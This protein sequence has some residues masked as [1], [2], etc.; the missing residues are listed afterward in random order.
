M[1]TRLCAAGAA[2]LSAML[3]A[4]SA[5][6]QDSYISLSGGGAFLADSDNAGQF[7]STFTTGA[8]TTIPAGTAL[9]AGTPLGWTTAFDTGYAL[10][11]AYGFRFADTFRVEF[12][13]AY[14][15]NDIDTHSGVTAAGI[16]LDGEDAGV[17]ITGSPNLGVSVGAL[18]DDGQGGVDTTYLMANVFYD[19]PA[20]DNAAFYIGGGLGVGFV[21]AEYAPSDITII[22][23][24]KSAFAYQAIAGVSYDVSDDLALFAQYRYRGTSDVELDVS[25]FDATLEIENRSSIVEVGLRYGF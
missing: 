7:T 16:L 17:L 12:E 14:Q 10:S 21:H 9:P 15:S 6:A 8:G 11:A 24:D 20:G 25:L 2:A 4:H 19:I 22:D 13:L 1:N 5:L 23:G 18:V 3:L